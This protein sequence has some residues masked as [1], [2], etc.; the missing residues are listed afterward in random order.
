MKIR[1]KYV[2][3]F[4]YTLSTL[5]FFLPQ[6]STFYYVY[7]LDAFGLTNAQ[8]GTLLSVFGMTSIPAYLFGG[9]VADKFQAKKLVLI[10]CFATGCLGIALTFVTQYYI[11][12]AIYVCFGITTTFLQWSAMC[13]IIRSMGNEA[14]QGKLFG[15][16]EMS[17]SIIGVIVLYG[18]LAL[19]GKLLEVTGFKIVTSVFGVLIIISG[20]LIAYLCDDPS[21]GIK[22]NDFDFKAVGRVLK[23]PVVW[24]N[25]FLVMGVYTL[26]TASTYLSPYLSE[27]VGISVTVAVAFQIAVMDVLSIFVSPLGGIAIDKFHTPPVAI[28]TAATCILMFITILILG[29]GATTWLIMGVVII[30]YISLNLLRPCMYTPVPEGGVPVEI[31]GTA[32]GIVS[33]IGYSTDTWL[34]TLCGSWL[35]KYGDAGYNRIWCLI[36]AGLVM[37]IIAISLFQIYKNK[38]K[39]E[40]EEALKQNYEV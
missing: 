4:I 36:I 9:Y 38:H 16:M 29:P 35:D 28:T 17:N 26:S 7:F 23:H 24:L 40:I 27:V 13:K 19:L 32:V 22:D 37:A 34:Y 25:G 39:T 10:A 1:N 14:E 31:T 8:A 3:V 20:L 2:K 5:V 6:L 11:L 15:T 33:A 18:I 12:L 30:L 21:L